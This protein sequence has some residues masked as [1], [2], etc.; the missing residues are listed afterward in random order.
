MSASALQ[1]SGREC[2]QR[3][4]AETVRVNEKPILS[5]GHT[6]ATR[7]SAGRAQAEAPPSSPSSLV[8][9]NLRPTS[10]LQKTISS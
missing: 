6:R 8:L 2:S 7:R 10:R 3:L 9:K 4:L 1:V 5:L